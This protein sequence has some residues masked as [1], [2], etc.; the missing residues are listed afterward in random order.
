MR[1]S[2]ITESMSVQTCYA[3]VSAMSGALEKLSR[4]LQREL[5][6]FLRKINEERRNE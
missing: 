4:I 2:L 5:E 1:E 3:K 6:L